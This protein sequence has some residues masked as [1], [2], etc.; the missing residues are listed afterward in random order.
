MTA[1]TLWV[2]FAFIPPTYHRPPVMVVERYTDEAKCKHF[3]ASLPPTT[4][5][6]VC[7]EGQ[8]ITVAAPVRSVS[9]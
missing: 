6:F 3:V 1:A 9:R 4:V 7:L 5:R 8:T 2:L